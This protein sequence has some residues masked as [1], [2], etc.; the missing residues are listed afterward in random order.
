MK[1]KVEVVCE[2]KGDQRGKCV[3]RREKCQ[4]HKQN[5]PHGLHETPF[6]SNLILKQCHFAVHSLYK[7]KH[8]S[9][10][11]PCTKVKPSS[12]LI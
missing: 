11:Y 1:R 4:D 2:E 10:A 8:S 6:H 9:F 5:I 7:L 12:T 3:N